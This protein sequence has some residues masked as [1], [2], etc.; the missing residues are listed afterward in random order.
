MRFLYTIST[1]YH[2][3]QRYIAFPRPLLRLVRLLAQ[4]LH[5]DLRLSSLS[6]QACFTSSATPFY[7]DPLPA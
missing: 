3:L 7:E 4:S 2:E 6:R 1:P 5:R